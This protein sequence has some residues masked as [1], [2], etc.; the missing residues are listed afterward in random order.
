MRRAVKPGMTLGLAN[1]EFWLGFRTNPKTG[2]DV[3]YKERAPDY[4]VSRDCHGFW[5]LLYV[6]K[7][8]VRLLLEDREH[9]VSEG[10]FILVAPGQVHSVLPSANVAPFYITAHFE[11]NLE[12][13]EDLS[14]SVV[15]ADEEGRRLLSEML[16]EQSSGELGA[17]ALAQSCLAQF[18][19]KAVRRRRAGQGAHELPT[20]FQASADRKTVD[21][22]IDYIRLQYAKPLS[23][24]AVAA[25]A[26]V[27]NS[28]LEH[29]FK[30]KTGLSVMRYLQ[31]LRI[32]E[33]KRL[34]LE[35]ALNVSQIAEKT[36]YSSVHLFS[37][38]FKKSVSVPPSRY[39]R[40]VRRAAP[41]GGPW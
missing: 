34:L 21:R 16:K 32:Q 35:S 37:R 24:D 40:M 22:A 11:T 8:V 2:V 38:R 19:I 23:L 7:G 4:A 14:N 31:D 15:A 10:E 1:G 12:H 17:R 3:R 5:E 9:V 27:S 28:H 13:L 20:Y 6:D 29:V 30:R 36:G 18:L 26:G 25:A 41:R 33:A 39:A